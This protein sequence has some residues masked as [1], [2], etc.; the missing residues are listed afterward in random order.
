[1]ESGEIAA[2]QIIASSQYNSNWS[3]ERSRLNYHE[4]GWTPSD[5]T[6]R[7]WIQVSRALIP[8]SELRLVPPRRRSHLLGIAFTH[9]GR[10][11]TGRHLLCTNIWS[12]AWQSNSETRVSRP[13]SGP[14]GAAGDPNGLH[15]PAQE[16]VEEAPQCLSAASATSCG[17]TTGSRQEVGSGARLVSALYCPSGDWF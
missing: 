2:Q 9:L 14:R 17:T 3:P 10:Q 8:E 11:E 16:L 4:N 12:L 5:D 13:H 15:C 1:M 6:V 7:E